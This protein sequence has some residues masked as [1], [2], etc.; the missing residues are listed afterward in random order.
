MDM[1]VMMHTCI[2]TQHSHK[3]AIGHDESLSPTVDIILLLLDY[4]WH[5]N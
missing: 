5:G 2:V 1:H 3:Q 4:I